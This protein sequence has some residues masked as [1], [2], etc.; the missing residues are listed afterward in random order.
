MRSSARDLLQALDDIAD[1]ATADA[2][3]D[4]ATRALACVAPGRYYSAALKESGSL[5]IFHPGEGWLGAEHEIFQLFDVL[6]S[7][8]QDCCD[9]PVTREYARRAGLRVI[10][11]SQLTPISEWLR[12]DHYQLVER[13]LSITDKVS[14]FIPYD[15]GVFS[16]HCG[17]EKDFQD[18]QLRA[19]RQL[20]QMIEPHVRTGLTRK[21]SSWLAQECLSERERDVLAW[22]AEGKRNAEIAT[23]MGV[24]YHTVRKHLEHAFVKLGVETRGAAVRAFREY[25]GR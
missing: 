22:V 16:L 12:S 2:V 8:G 25:S 24:S 4:A 11:R 10:A 7:S 19:L 5:R 6:R 23:I 15:G 13:Q 21:R 3:V 17:R 18:E 20:A 1:A 9:H 14:V